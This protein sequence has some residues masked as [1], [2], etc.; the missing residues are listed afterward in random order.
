MHKPALT[1]GKTSDRCKWSSRPVVWRQRTSNV[2]LISNGSS[3]DA[4]VNT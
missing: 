2:F 3:T 1:E 4:W